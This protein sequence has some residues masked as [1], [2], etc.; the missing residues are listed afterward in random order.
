MKDASPCDSCSLHQS[1]ACEH[2]L[3]VV[4]VVGECFDWITL[5]EC[6]AGTVVVVVSV[7]CAKPRTHTRKIDALRD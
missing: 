4:C 2:P 3:V 7:P 1:R 5:F 6:E